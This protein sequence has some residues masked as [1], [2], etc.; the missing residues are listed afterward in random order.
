MTEGEATA[1]G[2]ALAHADVSERT[3]AALSQ[4]R[5]RT[6][7]QRQA[8]HPCYGAAS[9]NVATAD[10]ALKRS[11]A[12]PQRRRSVSGPITALY[13]AP[14]SSQALTLNSNFPDGV[15]TQTSDQEVAS[16]SLAAGTILVH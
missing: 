1:L 13:S 15:E 10:S 6:L 3:T 14:I 8:V 2:A 12:R 11:A 7:G 5:Y 9:R 4:R 16:S